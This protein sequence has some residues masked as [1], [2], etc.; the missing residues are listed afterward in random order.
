MIVCDW[1]KG[2]WTCRCAIR[3][4]DLAN[5]IN[6][7]YFSACTACGDTRAASRERHGVVGQPENGGDPFLPWYAR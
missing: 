4:P 1:A 5:E 2:E 3:R 7:P 6:A